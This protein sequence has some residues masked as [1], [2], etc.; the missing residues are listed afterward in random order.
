[1]NISPNDIIPISDL[2]HGASQVINRL[3]KNKRPLVVT[4]NGKAAMVCM[5]VNEY[6][7]RFRKEKLLQALQ[8]AENDIASGNYVSL[9]DFKKELDKM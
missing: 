3:K 2:V 9:K 5:D 4:Q 1:M 7:R 8:E 6:E